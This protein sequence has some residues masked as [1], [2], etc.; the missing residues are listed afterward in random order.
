MALKIA[1]QA[2]VSMQF[3]STEQG[4]R[5]KERVKNGPSPPSPHLSFLGSRSIS[6]TAKTENPI[7]RSFFAPKPHG[8]LKKW[9]RAALYRAYSISFTSPIILF[10]RLYQSLKFRKRKESRCLEHVSTF[11]T[12]HEIRQFYVLRAVTAKNLQKSVMHVQSFCFANP[13]LLLFCRSCCQPRRR[14]LSSLLFQLN[15]HATWFCLQTQNLG[16]GH[17]KSNGVFNTST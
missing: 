16:K 9:I 6:R 13:N 2:S 3:W 14:C 10:A 11:C 12:K 4:T 15:R 5:V 1:C 17:F 8:N 7:P